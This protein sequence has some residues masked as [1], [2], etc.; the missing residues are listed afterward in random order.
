MKNN[1]IRETAEI[2]KRILEKNE[3]ARNDDNLLICL[4]VEQFGLIAQEKG[5]KRF[6]WNAPFY[7]ILDLINKKKIPTLETITRCRRKV[8]ELYPELKSKEQVEEA[9]LEKTIDY[10]N[11]A[12]DKR[13]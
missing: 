11:F 4:V 2:V 8:Q 13:I 10:I 12:K 7:A 5:E 3:K 9:R 1:K 6:T